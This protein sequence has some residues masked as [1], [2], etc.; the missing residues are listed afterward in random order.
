MS[1]SFVRSAFALAI[2]ACTSSA[3]RA[4]CGNGALE[5][6]ESCDDANVTLGDGCSNAC[7]IEPGWGCAGRSPSTCVR[8]PEARRDAVLVHDETRGV[9]VLFGG[10]A[11]L[12]ADTWEWDGTKWMERSATFPPAPRENAAATYD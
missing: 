8:A 10:Q 5:A 7:T 1:M 9:S 2:V 11:P 4:A 3:A 12:L 6:G